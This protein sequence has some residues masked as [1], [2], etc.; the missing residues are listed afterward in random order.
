MSKIDFVTVQSLKVRLSSN[1]IQ[2]KKEILITHQIR[3]CFLFYFFLATINVSPCTNI[4]HSVSSFC[5]LPS[6]LK[7]RREC[8]ILVLAKLIYP[9]IC[10]LKIEIWEWGRDHTSVELSGKIQMQ[11]CSLFFLLLLTT[12]F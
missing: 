5:L 4:K 1:N 7:L 6:L 11:L 2:E 3:Y 8:R 9:S 10:S 12:K